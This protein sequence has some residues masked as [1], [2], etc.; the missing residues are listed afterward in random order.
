[1]RGQRSNEQGKQR[2]ATSDYPLI[3]LPTPSALRPPPPPSAHPLRP[4]SRSVDTFYD[5]NLGRSRPIIIYV[6]GSHA[7]AL[8]DE[9]KPEEDGGEDSSE[10]SA[11]EP[12]LSNVDFRLSAASA[13]A[14]GKTP[15]AIMTLGWDHTGSPFGSSEFRECSMKILELPQVVRWFV[16]HHRSSSPSPKVGCSVPM[17]SAP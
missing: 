12:V 1:M 15:L 17:Q 14:D 5:D 10:E 6:T 16:S 4:P 2:Q 7:C 3:P 13:A 9:L 8:W 11:E